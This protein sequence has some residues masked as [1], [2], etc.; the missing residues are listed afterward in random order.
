MYFKLALNFIAQKTNHTVIS[1]LLCVICVIVIVFAAILGV[2]TDYAYSLLDT[3]LTTGVEKV[4][5]IRIG[6]YSLEFVDDLASQPEILSVGTSTTYLNNDYLQDLAKL[7]NNAMGDNKNGIDVTFL[8]N[9]LINYCQI[10]LQ[11]GEIITDFSDERKV[12]LY[13]GA[14]FKE[15]PVGTAY[16]TKWNDY[17]VAGIMCD[18]QRLISDSL[19]D[20]EQHRADYTYDSKYSVLAVWHAL[21]SDT[22]W[23]CAADNF[24]MDEALEKAFLIADKYNLELKFSTLQTRFEQANEDEMIMKNIFSRLMPIMCIACAIMIIC[25]QLSDVYSSL[26]EF[27]VLCSVGF[28]QG[29]I[30]KTAIIKSVITFVTAFIISLPL[31]IITLRWWYIQNNGNNDVVFRMLF[32]TAIPAAAVLVLCTFMVSAAI[33]VIVIRRHTPVQMIGGHN[34]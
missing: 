23:L 18:G 15:V 33:S 6:D 7:R 26:Y 12:Y 17:I 5:Q 21:S 19:S 22:M 25:M 1:V 29:D 32:K 11:S 8:N 2:G 4:S 20:I 24:T 30:E 10:A 14:G 34:D 28:T 16:S 31:I 27:G 9:N 3:L 13:L